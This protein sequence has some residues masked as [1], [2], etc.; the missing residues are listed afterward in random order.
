MA[1]TDG[2]ITGITTAYPFKKAGYTVGL[3]KR[4]HFGGFDTAN[5]SPTLLSCLNTRLYSMAAKWGKK[6]PRRSGIAG[7]SRSIKSFCTSGMEKIDRRFQ[8]D[9]SYLHAAPGTVGSRTIRTLH[10]GLRLA[11]EF[12]FNAEFVGSA[13][14]ISRPGIKFLHQAKFYPPKY[15][16]GKISLY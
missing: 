12:D 5:T 4:G 9:I 14:F 15:H 7:V 3:I 1:I 11:N 10:K 2:G 8:L 16:N 13:S 6:R